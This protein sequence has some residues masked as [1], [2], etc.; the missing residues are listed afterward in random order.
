M[1][2]KYVVTSNDRVLKSPFRH[3]YIDNEYRVYENTEVFP[4]AFAV[5]QSLLLNKEEDILSAIRDND[6]PLDKVVILEENPE[7]RLIL[8]SSNNTYHSIARIEEYEPHSVVVSVD[9]KADG[10]LVLSDCYFK[11]WRVY[12]D[13]RRDKIYR[14]DYIFRAVALKK[15]E[16][17][18]HF[19][20]KPFSVKLGL[21][22]NSLSFLL[23]VCI[24][25]M[26]RR[27][28]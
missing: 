8:P 11:G 21:I 24:F 25:I 13:G 23:I 2:I 16:H 9:M 3:V 12:V 10:Y 27:R 6:V 1:N 7:D 15:G 5:H 19:V 4:R 22:F 18:L 14:A 26:T 20:Y 17:K 28:R